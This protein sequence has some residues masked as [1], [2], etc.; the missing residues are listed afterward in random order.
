[1]RI[2]LGIIFASPTKVCIV[3]RGN[4]I[5]VTSQLLLLAINGIEIMYERA[6]YVD[7]PLVTMEDFGRESGNHS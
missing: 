6:D 7:L 3:I 1:M 5:V 4:I 2:T